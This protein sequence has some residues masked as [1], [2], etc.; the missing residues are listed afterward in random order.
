MMSANW[1]KRKGLVLISGTLEVLREGERREPRDGGPKEREG[2]SIGGKG[3]DVSYQSWRI[4]K[5]CAGE[6]GGKYL[7]ACCYEDNSLSFDCLSK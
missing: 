5:S 1:K 4:P 2:I 6:K 3:N 7:N